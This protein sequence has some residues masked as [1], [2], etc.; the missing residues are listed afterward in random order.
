MRMKFQVA[1][2]EVLS[3]MTVAHIT[4]QM[5]GYTFK[6]PIFVCDLGEI[7]CIFGLNAG[8]EA[9]FITS[10]RIGRIWFN[11]NKHDEP[12]QL[13]RSSIN[14]ICYLRAVK[15]FEL[16]PSILQRSK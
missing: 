11:A 4:I 3:S 2:G 16:K 6:L 8:N 12:K 13:F 14:A 7:D 1:N 10:A 5:Y 15:R 9:G